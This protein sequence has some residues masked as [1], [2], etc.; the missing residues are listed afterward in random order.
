C[1]SSVCTASVA[2]LGSFGQRPS[3]LQEKALQPANS[4]W[5][6]DRRADLA[7]GLRQPYRS[8]KTAKSTECKARRPAITAPQ[9]VSGSSPDVCKFSAWHEPRACRTAAR[10][11]VEG[12]RVIGTTSPGPLLASP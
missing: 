4:P 1:D 2:L 7:T 9:R 11:D 6:A 5:S 3:I 12:G 10:C 8:K